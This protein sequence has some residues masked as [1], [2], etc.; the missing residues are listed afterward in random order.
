MH[1]HWHEF[2]RHVYSRHDYEGLSTEHGEGLMNQLRIKLPL[3]EGQ[4]TPM[5]MIQ[6][7][8]DF[9]YHDPVDHHFSEQQ[10]IR[11]IFEN[12]IRIVYRLSGTGTEGTTLRI[13]LEQYVQNVTQQTQID[14]SILADYAKHQIELEKYIG[15]ALPSVRT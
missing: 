14:L 5:G 12:G 2:G 8:D 9:C 1:R 11:L 6:T 13:Y 4:V 7:A 10:G 15:R 3:L